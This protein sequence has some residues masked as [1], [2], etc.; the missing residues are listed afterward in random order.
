M[1]G[2]FPA[3]ISYNPCNDEV[4]EVFRADRHQISKKSEKMLKCSK[5][6]V[7]FGDFV[8]LNNRAK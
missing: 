1:C 7:K 2:H 6:C 4:D 3:T 8:K 5:I